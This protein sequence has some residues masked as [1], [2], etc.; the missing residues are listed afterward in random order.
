MHPLS[1]EEAASASLSNHIQPLRDHSS[2]SAPI[3]T[4][5]GMAAV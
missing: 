5:L 3:P 1:V 2:L 4:T